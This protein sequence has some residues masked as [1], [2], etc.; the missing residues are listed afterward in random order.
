MFE[1]ASPHSMSITRPAAVIELVAD[2][3]AAIRATLSRWTDRGRRD[4]RIP[5]CRPLH[6]YADLGPPVPMSD[7]AW[8]SPPPERPLPRDLNMPLSAF[9]PGALRHRPA[10]RPATMAPVATSPWADPLALERRLERL[11]TR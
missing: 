4:P 8:M 2:G 10:D 11:R 3:V 1:D 7:Q 5:A 9:D 6:A